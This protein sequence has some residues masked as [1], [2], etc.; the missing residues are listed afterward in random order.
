MTQ[1]QYRLT[2]FAA[3]VL[4]VSVR[5]GESSPE[6]VELFEK[7]IRPVLVQHC[8]RCHSEKSEKLKGGLR[9]DGRGLLLKGGDSGPAL[10]AGQ[11]EKSKLIEALTYKN[12]DLEMPPKG[13]LPDAV[14]A[15]F[16]HWVRLDAPWP[17]DGETIQGT[18]PDRVDIEKRKRE[19]WSW[20]PVQPQEA[21][22]VKDRNWVRDPSDAFIL[23]K[24]EALGLKPAPAADK[25]TWLRRVTFD[26]IGLPPAPAEIEAFLKD[27]SPEAHARV[28]DRLLKS[29]HFGERWARHWLDLVRYGE[30]RGHEFEPLLPNAYQ[31]RDYVIRALNADVPYNQFALEHLAGD[32]L[33][34]PRRHPQEGFNES[35]LGSGFWFLGEEV[36]SPVDIRQDQADRF[37]NRLDVMTKTFLGLTVSCARC[38][39]HKFD[40]IS[41]RDYYSLFGFLSSSSYRLAR[42]DSLDQNKAVAFDLAKL[43]SKARGEVSK[44]LAASAKPVTERLAD[45][46]LAVR[47][48][49]QGA[50][51]PDTAAMRKLDPMLLG[52]WVDVVRNAARDRDDPFHAWARYCTDPAAK[53]TVAEEMRKRQVAA[54]AA[55]KNAEVVIDYGHCSPADWLP[56]DAAFGTGPA[57]PGD[58]RLSGDRPRFVE[59]GAAE[60]DR[61]FDVLRL[62]PGAENDP[63][64]LGRIPMRAGRTLCTP[65]F[66]VKTGKVFYLVRGAGA[67]YASVSAHVVVEGPL[68]GQLVMRFPASAEFRWVSQ[69]LTRY[70]GLDAHIEFTAVPG[71]DLAVA[72]VVQAEQSPG[73]IDRPNAA[74]LGLLSGDEKS[75]EAL[76]AAYGK[77]FAEVARRL[78]ADEVAGKADA[79][80]L[81][82][83]ANWL[84]A[85]PELL[86]DNAKPI[87]ATMAG[88]IAEE[89]RIAGGIKAESRLALAMLDGSSVDEHV[90]VRGSPKV[91]GEAA[92][93]RLLEAL[94]GS[95]PLHSAPGSGR[96]ELAR[97]MTDPAVNP[98]IARVMVNRV[99]HHLYGRGLVASVDNFGVMG[100]AP[101]HPELLDFLA[102]RFVKEGWSLK[103]LIRELALSNAYRMSS[104]PVPE[105]EKLDPSNLLLHRMRL[106][107]LE[108]EAIRDALLSVS[109]RLDRTVFG[110]SVPIYLTP[111]LDGRGRPGSGPLD[112]NGRRSLY[113]AVK[114]NF[115]SPMML[116]FDTPSPFSTVGRRTV[117][118]VPAQALILMN[119]P[120]VHQQAGL[121][122]KKV[123]ASPGTAEQR[124][125]EMYL[126]AFG[127][128]PTDGE[129][130]ACAAFLDRGAE[131]QGS[132]V[133][134]A[135]VWTD[136]AHTLF[137]V[138]EFIFLN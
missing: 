129:R 29:P 96:L 42:F 109:G 64:A 43:R 1:W 58:L 37:D 117:S 35:I 63:G 22:A 5:A 74:L 9:V 62:K 89:K 3:L 40:A 20:R 132:K 17:N 46:L 103:T 119:D 69:D 34:K 114:R 101:T 16:V 131:R 120:F 45:Y 72:M 44:A 39:D 41:T 113:L 104:Q 67:V 28:V 100:E 30:S 135:K 110:P 52:K 88:F 92:P 134:D 116:A 102:G 25:R 76:A 48:V 115:L 61:A 136:L 59:R 51:Q 99:W 14:I 107:R 94:A 71:S 54:E 66:K 57:R 21:P 11:P 118:N 93:R 56:D 31:Y 108:G 81:A 18:K 23:A 127:R 15:D 84:A 124:V 6:A 105:A 60:Y 133:E 75:A 33:D 123:L 50:S 55:L 26:L 97:Q 24:L 73:P 53:K 47:A 86:G 85:R 77:L 122:A 32:L 19:H 121:W 82:R 112:G 70:K 125:T 91:E 138:K 79:A 95:K 36:H 90:F 49:I 27:E 126:S 65:S 4:A 13:K 7:K 2:S 128:P 98:F 106:R 12:P 83:L 137:N 87:S 78:S 38:H 130:K 80:D 111:F 68:H 10:V 8:Y